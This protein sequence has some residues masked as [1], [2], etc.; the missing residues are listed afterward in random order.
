M[1]QF[2]KQALQLINDEGFTVESVAEGRHCKIRVC[3]GRRTKLLVVSKSPSD[4]QRALR[5]V[6]QN[7][8]AMFR[9]E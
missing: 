6:R 8:R 7:L 4:S 1:Q 5:N 9:N 2:A 3:D